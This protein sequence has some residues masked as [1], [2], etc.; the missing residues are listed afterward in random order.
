MSIGLSSLK[1]GRAPSALTPLER[2]AAAEPVPRPGESLP[3]SAAPL[4]AGPLSVPGRGPSVRG[5]TLR[6]S[7]RT[8]MAEG[9]AAEVV[10]A[11]AGGAVLTGWALHLGAGPAT[12]GVLGAL[13]LAAQ[14]V[15]GPAA[16]LTQTIGPKLV[17]VI[18][19]GASRLVWAPLIILPFLDLSA[20]TG[21]ALLVWIV[22]IGAVLGVV[23]NNAWTTWMGELVPSQVRGRFFSRRMVYL[24]LSG[25]LA[26]L[27]AGVALDALGPRGWHGQTLAALAAVACAAGLVSIWLLLG[28][29]DAGRGASRTSPGWRS[30]VGPLRD[31]RTRSFLVYLLWWNAAVGLSASYFSFHMLGNLQ[32]GFAL[33]AAHGIVVA[34]VRIL[35]APMWGRL[36]DRFGGRPVLVLCS[37]GISVV[38]AIWLFPTPERLW[39]IAFEAVLAGALWGGHG[40]AAFDLSIGLSPGRDRPFHLAAFATASGIGFAV[41]SSLAGFLAYAGPIELHLLSPSWR[42]VHVLFLL[43]ALGRAAA[44]ALALK[45]HEPAA[46]GVLDVARALPWGGRHMVKAKHARM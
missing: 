22:G 29:A 44:G 43:S 7:L 37:F 30:I 17:G 41:A 28:Q 26:S 20:S 39:P 27:G 33:T 24:S 18:A 6:A 38:P 15:Q 1:P 32:M 40:I 31:R 13:P 10:G 42:E 35:S 16:W 12:I 46:R 23:G 21:L 14:V 36:V 9:A 5:H 11:C 25:T 2:I 45:I 3:V 4:T 34:A 19:I 8:S